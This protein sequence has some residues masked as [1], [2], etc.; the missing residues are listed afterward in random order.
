M[1]L[2]AT[3]RLI[4]RDATGPFIAFL[5]ALHLA[6]FGLALATARTGLAGDVDIRRFQAIAGAPG[7]PYRD[8]EVEY[9]PVELAAIEV[10]ASTDATAT[11]RRVTALA[12]VADLVT[13]SV[14][15]WGWGRRVAGAYLLVSLPLLPVMVARLDPLV[16]ALAAAGFAASYR[17]RERAGG[18]LLGLACLAKL[19]PLVLIPALLLQRR[20]RTA[21]WFTG[22]FAAGLGAWLAVGGVSGVRQVI[23]FRGASGWQIESLIGA[24]VHVLTGGPIHDEAGAQRVGLVPGWGEALLL[25]LLIAAV[26]AVWLR[27]RGWTGTLAGDPSLAALG[28]LL[29][30]SPVFSVQYACWLTPWLAIGGTEDRHRAL[31]RVAF[32]I[33]LLTAALLPIYER[34][35]VEPWT[36]P[37]TE[38]ILIARGSLCLALPVIWWWSRRETAAT[39]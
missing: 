6:A 7:V 1:S 13:A 35:G 29:A 23:T 30:L 22:T 36:V 16:V 21:A 11:A 37:V 19:W 12:F 4:G 10:V 5:L 32:A 31:T 17:D 34:P 39:A 15:A 38:A 33:V 18:I 2:G 27:A 3:P 8:V 26:T 9:A 24:V 20:R 25:A 14:L 28:T